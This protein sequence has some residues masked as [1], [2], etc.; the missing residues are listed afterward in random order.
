MAEEVIAGI[1]LAAGE[2]EPRRHHGDDVEDDDGYVERAQSPPSPS[3]S[4]TQQK[5]PR[6]AR[7]LVTTRDGPQTVT[8]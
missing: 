5:G 8:R 1:A 3:P 6:R 7:A 4:V 2:E